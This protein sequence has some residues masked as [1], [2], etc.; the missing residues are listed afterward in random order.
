MSGPLTVLVEQVDNGLE[1]HKELG[2]FA[3]PRYIIR[4]NYPRGGIT[5]AWT[6]WGARR[7]A[8]QYSREGKRA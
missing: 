5:V 2:L 3:A 6:L 1:I 4:H 7:I 8:R